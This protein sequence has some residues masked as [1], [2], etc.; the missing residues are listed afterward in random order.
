MRLSRIKWLNILLNVL[1]LVVLPFIGGILIYMYIEYI[2]AAIFII[3]GLVAFFGE[4]LKNGA[5]MK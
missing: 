3:P 4:A 1:V 2:F 5:N